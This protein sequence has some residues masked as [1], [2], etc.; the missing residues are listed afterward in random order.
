[1][2]VPFIE[3]VGTASIGGN[4]YSSYSYNKI[5]ILFK[6]TQNELI[7]QEIDVKIL[8]PSLNSQEL[9]ELDNL[10]NILGL[11]FL[12]KDWRFHCDLKNNEVYFEKQ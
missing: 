4:K 6:S 9:Q 5:S 7:T 8:R 1:M 10:P 11:D 12:K 2:S 3:R